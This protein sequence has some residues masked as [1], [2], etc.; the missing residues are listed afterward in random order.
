MVEKNYMNMKFK[1][2]EGENYS[3]KLSNVRD[4]IADIV[5]SIMETIVDTNVIESGSGDLIKAL[6]AKFYETTVTDLN[7]G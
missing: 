1:T 2:A 7:I 4:D 5:S 6:D 3:I